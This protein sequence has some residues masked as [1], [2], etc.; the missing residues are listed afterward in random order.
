M[1]FYQKHVL[2]R[3]IHLS[4]GVKPVRRQREK[5]VP[6]AKGRVLE[7][8]IG[9]GLN[10]PFYGADNID[11]LWGLDPSTELLAYAERAARDVRF[12]VEL[13]PGSAENIPLDDASADTVLV[14][15]SL[16]TIPDPIRAL[17]DVHRV[18]RPDGTLLFCEHG[19]SPDGR[20]HRWQDRLTPV[21]AKI[22]G[23]CHLNRPI[24][25][26]IEQGGFKIDELETM[27]LP[28]PKPMTFNYWG[29]ARP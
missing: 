15:Y 18:L 1:G 11:K 3:L 17:Q 20:V 6:R 25:R 10:L 4:C 9:S 29:A 26:L 5:I 24:P 2:P 23:G 16:C 27:Y 14:T 8:G 19:L 21:W 13:I 22:G 7:I 12:D 28:G